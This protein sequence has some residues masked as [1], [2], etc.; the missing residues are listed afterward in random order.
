MQV[1]GIT[2]QNARWLQIS[3]ALNN[4]GT[5]F[6][7]QSHIR[8]NQLLG[9]NL[10]SSTSFFQLLFYFPFQS[11]STSRCVFDVIQRGRREKGDHRHI[12][13][14]RQ[15]HLSSSSNLFITRNHKP[16]PTY[17][18]NNNNKIKQSS[19]NN[20]LVHY[21]IILFQQQAKSR[22]PLNKNQKTDANPENG[23]I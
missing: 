14:S 1:Q 10:C 7:Q 4:R 22:F 21:F 3:A 16:I 6:Q 20:K 15:T 8:E 12:M 5:K 23:K 13:T 19:D 9:Q 11:F 17:E 2:R 18:K